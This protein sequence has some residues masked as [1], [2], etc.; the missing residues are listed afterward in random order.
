MRTELAVEL[1]RVDAAITTRLVSTSGADIT[2][3]K[4]K[5]DGL[6]AAP[7]AVSD[8]PTAAT[9]ASTVWAAVTRTLTSATGITAADVWA[10]AT[11]TTTSSSA[12]TA[13]ANA[14]AVRTE[15]AVEL[16]RVD[17]AVSTRAV[18]VT[19]P[20][21]TVLPGSYSNGSAGSALGKLNMA[22]GTGPVQVIPAAPADTGVCRVF[23]YFET[24]DN[25]MPE[26]RKVEIEF[27]LV[28]P[29]A[30][31][32]ERLIY[33]RI[34]RAGLNAAGALVGPDGLLYVDLNRTDLMTPAGATYL[35]TSK[36]L[37]VQSK[38]ITLTTDTANL[39]A[40]LLA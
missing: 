33:G 23:G 16:G 18:P 27:R 21:A 17:V 28:T 3:I 12:P 10:Y 14:A 32:S 31:A 8:I 19:D 1:A 25:R 6:P 35:V 2:S 29:G 40:L 5:T 37:G 13:A 30:I 36:E 9:V 26:A 22:A 7:A 24:P 4:A 20:W 39:R 15:L 11:R 34:V 38:P